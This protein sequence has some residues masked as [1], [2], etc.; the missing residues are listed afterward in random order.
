M[1]ICLN[2]KSP[3]PIK[4]WLWGAKAAQRAWSLQ[5]KWEMSN[6]LHTGSVTLPSNKKMKIGKLCK[7]AWF[8]RIFPIKLFFP[9]KCWRRSRIGLNALANIAIPTSHKLWEKE[10]F[11]NQRFM[12][13]RTFKV[14]MSF[15]FSINYSQ[16]R[17]EED[18]W[19]SICKTVYMRKNMMF[20]TTKGIFLR[21]GSILCP[22]SRFLFGSDETM[23]WPLDIVMAIT[24]RRRR[25]AFL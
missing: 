5:Q 16:R 1:Y 8:H 17:V 18:S 12:E 9:P 15:A 23:W 21:P 6:L 10:N 19:Q 7:T 13:M 20:A 24:R 4:D 3:S 2:S 11:P 25:N 14:I 22:N